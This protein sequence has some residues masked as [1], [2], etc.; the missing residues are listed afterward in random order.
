M[1]DCLTK[2]CDFPESRHSVDKTEVWK[3]IEAFFNNPPEPNIKVMDLC[4]IARVS[5]RTLL[6]L[7]KVRFGISPK[8]YINMVRLNGLH[9][10]LKKT[11]MGKVKIVEIANRWGFWH[12]GQLAK[13]YKKMFKELP[14]ET[15]KKM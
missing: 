5:E 3:R 7:F 11:G 2:C 6:R 15:L 8:T 12:M 13:D 10:D 1:A 14:S 9:R 4:R